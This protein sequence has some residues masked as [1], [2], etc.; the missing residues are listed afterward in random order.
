MSSEFQKDLEALLDR[1]IAEAASVTPN[2][3]LA[4]YLVSCLKAFNDA[5]NARKAHR[6]QSRLP[7][8]PSSAI[9]ATSPPIEGKVF[10]TGPSSHA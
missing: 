6:L 2:H 8:R 5:V 9:A 3:V 1:H 4:E 10:R 7:L